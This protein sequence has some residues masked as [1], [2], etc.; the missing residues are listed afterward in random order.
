MEKNTDLRRLRGRV[1]EHP[2]DEGRIVT[3]II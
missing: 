1:V 2:R 3:E